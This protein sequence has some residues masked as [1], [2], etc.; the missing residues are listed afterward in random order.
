MSPDVIPIKVKM[1]E[2]MNDLN[3]TLWPKSYAIPTAGSKL[4]A[5]TDKHQACTQGWPRVG[6]LIGWG[7]GGRAPSAQCWP[8]RVWGHV[9]PEFVINLIEYGV[10]FCILKYKSLSL[11]LSCENDVQV[12]VR[13]MGGGEGCR[14]PRPPPPLG[15]GL[16]MVHSLPTIGR[17]LECVI[18]YR[19]GYCTR[20][21]PNRKEE[22]LWISTWF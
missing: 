19:T 11:Y 2:S 9:P 16:N 15:T 14:T 8:R 17:H 1:W 5:M 18:L 21:S 13:C 6:S 4:W 22:F 12:A 3:I 7:G 20:V 10:S